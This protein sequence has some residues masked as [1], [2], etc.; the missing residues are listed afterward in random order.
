MNN[1]NLNKTLLNKPNIN[2]LGKV[3]IHWE[4]KKFKNIA[5]L[6]KWDKLDYIELRLC[7][8]NIE[9]ETG[10]YIES[11]SEFQGSGNFIK[12]NDIL[13]GK[14]RPY[15][16]KVLLSNFY[17]ECVSEIYVF[18]AI[19]K[20]LF[21]K[22]LYYICISCEFIK[23]V[24][25]FAFGS[26]MPRA[27]W[28]SIRNIDV[29]MPNLST[30]KAIVKF[31]DYKTD[32]I[33]QFITDK[34]DMI[35]RLYE[36]K[37][38]LI[39]N[40]VT[41]GIEK[42]IKYKSSGIPWIGSV[43]QEWNIISLKLISKIFSGGTPSKDINEYWENGTIPW[44]ASGE[45][46]Q[47]FITY[48]TTYIT[49]EALKNSSAKWIKQNS[50]VIALAGQG[51]TKG[52]VGYLEFESTCN[53]SLGVIEPNTRIVNEKFLYYFLKSIYNQIRGLTGE[54]IRD[55]LNLQLIGQ[56]KIPLTNL[57]NQELIVKYLDQETAKIDKLIQTI[58]KEIELVEEYQKSLIY[59]AVTG[60][61]EIV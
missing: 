34:K 23:E 4:V 13:F 38:S 49:E 28:S 47:G 58:T 46:N 26:K 54:D 15:L 60:K 32:L 25:S 45:V 19:E 43:P 20:I 30:Q 27:D 24:N 59:K 12:P 8:E 9:S 21:Y 6:N 10:R 61:L 31:L 2:W 40:A 7:L 48:P 51:K 33:A 3:P 18:S 42:D 39:Y 53:Q 14:L 29:P 1:F 56:L 35:E 11:D 22:F 17:G 50:L 16:A 44:L 5:S 55:G 37:Q 57:N 41:K 52:M 36:Q